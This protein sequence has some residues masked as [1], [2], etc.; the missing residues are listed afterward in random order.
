MKKSLKKGLILGLAF[1]MAV[2]IG[3]A[4][5]RTKALAETV[6]VVTPTK[7]TDY[8]SEIIPAQVDITLPGKN[9]ASQ[10]V[11]V[12]L[13]VE[14]AGVVSVQ[15]A[16]TAGGTATIEMAIFSDE[17]CTQAVGA[18]TSIP[19]GINQIISK[20]FSIDKAAVYYLRFK[21]TSIVPETSASITMKT[22]AYNGKAVTLG[23]VMQ[24]IYTGTGA[25]KLYHKIVV[26]KNKYVVI[27]GNEIR[28]SGNSLQTSDLYFQLC[29]AKKI[30]LYNGHLSNLNLYMENFALKKG[31]YYVAVSS[32]QRYQ[33]LAQ[34]FNWKNKGGKNKKKAVLIKKGKIVQGMSL[35][36]DKIGKTKWYKVRLKKKSKLRI[37]IVAACTGVT[38]NM[39]VTVVPAKKGHRLINNSFIFGSTGKKI[40]S[41]K[42]LSKG[43]YYI[44]ISKVTSSVSCCYAI[45]YMK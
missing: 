31:T 20:D 9:A 40:S 14:Q 29:N 2:G 27:K 30:P 6:S 13:R 18:V 17:S 11:I 21:W 16:V 8:A 42:K 12:P 37:S 33:L 44:K 15:A 28:E 19:S 39:K 10:N 32:S 26:K 24:P 1:F 34:Q 4:C 22:V 25:K 43:T 7:V 38:Q 36:S 41:R 3:V 5:K 35:M 45:K 23:N